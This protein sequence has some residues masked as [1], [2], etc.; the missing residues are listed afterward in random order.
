MN[1]LEIIE[2]EN[3]INK[4]EKIIVS[5]SGGADSIALLHILYSVKNILDI[6]IIVAHFN[7]H[8]RGNDSDTDANFVKKLA[9]NLN[10]KSF[11]I[12]LDVKSHSLENKKGTEESARELRYLHLNKIMQEER[13]HKIATAHTKDDKV[14]TILM[15]ILRGSGIKGLVGLNYKSNF[16]IK[17]L[18]SFK[19][20]EILNYLSENNIAYRTDASNFENKFTRNKIRNLLIPFIKNN[21]NYNIENSLENL[22]EISNETLK[23]IYNY[24]D[25]FITENYFDNKISNDKI[26]KE[27]LIIRY[28]VIR[29]IIK[30]EKGNYENVSLAEIKRIENLLREKKHFKTELNGGELYATSDGVFFYITQKKEVHNSEKTFYYQL[31][32]DKG[33]YIPELEINIKSFKAKELC[34]SQDRFYFMANENKKF[35]IN[36][37]DKNSKNL[38]FSPLGMKGKKKKISDILKDKKIPLDERNNYFILLDENNNLLWIPDIITS[39]LGKIDKN[40]M[41]N[42]YALII[43]K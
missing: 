33:T 41:K 39:E 42:I 7:H 22:S 24:S 16:I 14:E 11:I 1:I 10:L 36:S 27:S 28:H 43:E 34:F 35:F 4:G 29:K 18:I 21:F 38:Y 5:V 19:K 23:F 6:K 20:D 40:N 32:L 12:D 3:L 13:A 9:D 17:P 15:N 30:K 31:D 8:L 26:L 37:I 25:K 2:K